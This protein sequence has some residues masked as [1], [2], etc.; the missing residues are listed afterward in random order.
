MYALEY[1]NG[2]QWMHC[3]D[4]SSAELA[5]SSL[6]GDNYNYRVVDVDGNILYSNTTFI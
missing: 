2:K 4:W 6:G 3:K 5:W 1:Y